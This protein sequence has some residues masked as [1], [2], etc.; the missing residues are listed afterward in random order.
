MREFTKSGAFV[1]TVLVL[2][3]VLMPFA[4]E[5]IGATTEWFEFPAK[6]TISGWFTSGEEALPRDHD[7]NPV[8]WEHYRQSLEDFTAWAENREAVAISP[9][10][11]EVKE[12]KVEELHKKPKRKMWPV[13]VV[14]C[15]AGYLV[16][17]K[18][19]YA[20]ISGFDGMI[21]E[22]AV[23]KPSKDRCGYE[24]IFIGERSVWFRAVFESEGDVPMGIVKL[25]EF[26]RVEGESLVK[27]HRKFV[28]RDAFPLKF[29]GWL[30]IDSFMPPDGVVFKILDANRREVASI[31][32]V[33]IGEKGAR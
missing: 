11:Y 17:R 1:V 2:V 26:T 19:G 9:P 18:K 15:T 24:I 4:L 3:V 12:I 14:S 8:S 29:G 16:G 31:L 27:G 20:F 33:V 32:C 22:G 5:E 13:S 10:Q 23:I 6:K 28:A 30:M 7:D 25:P 21:E